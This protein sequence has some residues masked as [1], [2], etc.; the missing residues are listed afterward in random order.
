MECNP[1]WAKMVPVVARAIFPLETHMQISPNGLAFIASNE[2]F[3][4]TPY[5][6]NGKLAWGYGHDQQ[7]GE[8]IPA[9][10]SQPDALALLQSDL[11]GRFEA[12]VNDM[13][14][15]G[16][17][18]NQFDALCDF[19]YNL[20]CA[21]LK[22]MLDH[23][24]DQVPVQIPRWDHVNGVVSAGLAMRRAKEVELFNL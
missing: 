1:S 7:P 13:V 22:T 12:S 24:W 15:P 18:Q 14:M 10:I 8:A 9:S 11:S 20:G 17:T 3:A 21:S 16:C 19:A 4:A 23:G 2:G 5:S 6:D